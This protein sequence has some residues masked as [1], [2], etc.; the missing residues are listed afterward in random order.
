LDAAGVSVPQNGL[1]EVGRERPA[2]Y[3][4]VKNFLVKTRGRGEVD[5]IEGIGKTECRL[6]PTAH[7]TNN[8]LRIQAS[9]SG[10]DP[11]DPVFK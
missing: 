1:I 8:E 11:V 9:D 2:I 7:K 4:W 3:G 10:L 5:S 6:V